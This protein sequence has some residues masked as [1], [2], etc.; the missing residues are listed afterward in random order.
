MEHPH[1][2]RA[3][4]PSKEAL[5][6]VNS[7]FAVAGIFRTREK[8]IRV[9]NQIRKELKVGMNEA[10]ARKLAMQIY[11]DHGAKK[12]WH[13]IYVRI[14]AGT[15]LTFNEPDESVATLQENDPV[16]MDVGPVFK[17]DETNLEYEGDY[18]DSFVFSAQGSGK[19]PPAEKCAEFA[20]KLFR[21]ASL[22]W[23]QEKLTGQEIYQFLAKQNE[24]SGYVLHPA[25]L[26]HRLSDFPHQRYT[27]EHLS[28]LSFAPSPD[29]WVL[30]VHLTD[31]V[32]H[33]GAFYED[34]LGV[35]S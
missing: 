35:E 33:V 9:F 11:A 17:D 6:A 4:A 19:N 20:R 8:T 18:G 27:T 5:E 10:E 3:T 21:E 24:G 16:Y 22:K 15:C 26:G 25:V 29:L 31:P 7:S 28:D 12:H 13:R 23:K 34:I 2:L 30:E 14:G 32:H 1:T